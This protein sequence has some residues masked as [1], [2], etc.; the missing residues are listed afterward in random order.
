MLR[1]YK[2]PLTLK[3]AVNHVVFFNVA[4]SFELYNLSC[5]TPVLSF[6]QLLHI[7][8]DIMEN[9]FSTSLMLDDRVSLNRLKG[10]ISLLQGYESSHGLTS[11]TMKTIYHS[12]IYILASVV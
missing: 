7:I 9:S 4:A 8:E 3:L 5:N 1:G 2:R 6:Y 12:E 11:L 10:N